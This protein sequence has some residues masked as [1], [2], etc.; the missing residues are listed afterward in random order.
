MVRGMKQKSMAERWL[1]LGVIA[2]ALAGIFA[3][4]LVLARTPQLAVFTDLF[5]VALVIHVDLSVMLW[6]LAMLGMGVACMMERAPAVWNVW[7]KGSFYTISAATALMALSPIHPQWEVIKSNYIPVLHNPVFLLSLG[8]LFAGLAV[9][10]LPPII[11]FALRH[12]KVRLSLVEMG[13]LL[14]AMVVAMALL[15]F[16]MSASALPQNL[17]HDA[18]Y[19]Q[20]FWAGGHVWQF[21]FCLL[22]M[23]AW[24]VLLEALKLPLPK[25]SA[26]VIAYALTVVGAIMSFLGFAMHAHDSGAFTAYQTRVMVELGGV[27]VGLLGLLVLQ[28]LLGWKPQRATRAYGSVLIASLVLFGG[29]GILGLMISGQNVTIPAHY[30]GAIVGITL[31][32]MGLAYAMLPVFGYASV[33]ATR[34]AFWQPIVYGAGQLMHI[35][36]L[37]YSG[38]YGVLR[39]T[40]GAVANSLTPDVKIAMGVM[41]TGGLLAVIG[42]ILFVVVMAKAYAA[43]SQKNS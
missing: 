1:W 22:M 17:P 8:L 36:G 11:T 6:F 30:H 32:L 18:R 10:V 4:V 41:G 35:G 28:R 21:A 34:L 39:K 7:L 42:G 38:G 31:S 29:G 24:L 37:A 9:L 40:P 13:W 19:E 2:L 20:L 12:V 16:S 27:G 5:S 33:A 23:A 43:G 25:R 15:A 3:V 26:V 14:A